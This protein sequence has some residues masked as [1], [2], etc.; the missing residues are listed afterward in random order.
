MD[1]DTAEILKDVVTGNVAGLAIDLIEEGLE[2]VLDKEI[3]IP[4]V[5]NL[6][7]LAAGAAAGIVASNND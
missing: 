5:I 4:K 1:N 6:V 7:E 3:E 2:M